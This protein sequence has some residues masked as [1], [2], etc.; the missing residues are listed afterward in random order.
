MLAG[1]QRR[2]RLPRPLR[3]VRPRPPTSDHLLPLHQLPAA[4]ARLLGVRGE[5][6]RARR[7][8][9]LG[10][11]GFRSEG[12]QG[13]AGR[14]PARRLRV[15][16]RGRGGPPRARICRPQPRRLRRGRPAA[17][18]RRVSPTIIEPRRPAAAAAAG[19]AR[20]AGEGYDY[21][22]GRPGRERRSVLTLACEHPASTPNV[23]QARH[24]RCGAPPL[25]LA[26]FSRI[27]RPQGSSVRG[28]ECTSPWFGAPLL[29][30]CLLQFCGWFSYRARERP[31][32]RG[33]RRAAKRVRRRPLRGRPAAR[34]GL[35]RIQREG[36][37][38]PFSRSPRPGPGIRRSRH[39]PSTPT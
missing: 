35:A 27:E 37:S 28:G 1:P 8:P 29:G 19:A 31:R 17:R 13:H 12:G 15:R 20:R 22:R 9:E 25:E 34:V 23:P 10:R 6:E 18:R 2:R 33:G 11:P 21:P 32:A 26:A 38:P 3:R 5:H 24:P 7:L 16:P 14:S 36:R 39:T 4:G 30:P